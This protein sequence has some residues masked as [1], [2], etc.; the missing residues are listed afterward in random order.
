M[1]LWL[2]R[3]FKFRFFWFVGAEDF[4]AGILHKGILRPSRR[5]RSTRRSRSVSGTLS[6]SAA[7]RA[8]ER[9]ASLWNSVF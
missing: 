2:S 8:R 6:P 3:F 7:P 9:A 4:G 5:S 1:A